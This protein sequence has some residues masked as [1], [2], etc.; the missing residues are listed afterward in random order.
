M[1]DLHLHSLFS[2]DSYPWAS[3]SNICDAAALKGLR[4]ICF[5]DHIDIDYPSF[6]EI[7][8]FQKYS[9]EIDDMI[10]KYK[11]KLEVFKGLELGLQPH[12]AAENSS[13]SSKPGIDFILGS[14][15]VVDKKELY[16]GDFLEN[17]SDEEGVAAYFDDMNKSI[18]SF[19][20]F[21]SLG[22]ID[23]V[24]RYLKNGEKA[25]RYDLYEAAIKDILKTLIRMGKGIEINTSGKRYGLS[26]YHPMTEILILYKKLGG[27]IITIG[28]DAHRPEDLA[29]DF[30]ELLE[31]LKSLDYKYYCI[32]KKRKPLF[33]RIK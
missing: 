28:S 27:E 12:L 33:I 30:N 6:E 18:Y 23:V 11:D 4:G 2:S 22:H 8:D 31:L 32:F 21:D 24:R 16:K 14:I 9:N 26:S 29:Y 3:M 20:D 19:S 10:Y 15:H 13:F 7:P 5:T 1:Y 17:R 25:F